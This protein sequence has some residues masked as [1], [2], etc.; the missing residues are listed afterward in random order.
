MSSVEALSQIMDQ[1]KMLLEGFEPRLNDT[2][3]SDY[4]ILV[5]Q[6]P[7]D[8]VEGDQ[9]PA[10]VIYAEAY[11]FDN[12][13][14]QGQTVHTALLNFDV[15]ETSQSAGVVGR[16]ARSAIAEIVRAIH[17]DRT[18]GGRLEDAQERNVAPPMD[19]G[20]SIGGASLQ[21]AIRFYTSRGDHFTIIS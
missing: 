13:F 11:D 3:F 21:V 10:V 16:E 18:L 6:S 15:I 17:S 8:A 7:D 14:E 19:N 4:T 5:D 9:I 1:Y 12:D 20:R 2:P